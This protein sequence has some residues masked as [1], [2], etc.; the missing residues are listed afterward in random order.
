MIGFDRFTTRRIGNGRLVPNEFQ[1][2]LVGWL[3]R[4]EIRNV[5]SRGGGGLSGKKGHGRWE[6]RLRSVEFNRGAIGP[7]ARLNGLFLRWAD[8]F[9]GKFQTGQLLFDI[10]QALHQFGLFNQQRLALFL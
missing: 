9:P 7:G 10:A 3:S 8:I 5:R 1:M 4:L 6:G 2:H